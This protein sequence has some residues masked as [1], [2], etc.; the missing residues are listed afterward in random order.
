LSRTAKKYQT[1]NTYNTAP[2]GARTLKLQRDVPLAPCQD[3]AGAAPAADRL[4]LVQSELRA[5]TGLALAHRKSSSFDAV[6]TMIE[7][8]YEFVALLRAHQ[9][10]QKRGTLVAFRHQQTRGPGGPYTTQTSNAVTT[11]TQSAPT[12]IDNWDIA[13]DDLSPVRGSSVKFDAGAYYTGKEK[14]LIDEDRKFIVIDRS[15]GWQFLK[16][17][18]PPEWVMRE[19]GTPRPEQP[20]ADECTWP[21][22]LNGEPTHP[23]KYTLFLYLIDAA[24]GETLTFSS[25]TAGGRNAVSDLTAQ[26]KNMRQMR[27]GAVPIVTLQSRQMPTKFGKKPRPHFQIKGWKVRDERPAAVSDRSDNSG[28]A[29]INVYDD[30][31]PF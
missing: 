10:A 27:P 9:S 4:G 16:K 2:G 26:I 30:E 6:K 14:T 13:A 28:I 25:S 20:F 23:W 21:A 3:R 5:I 29:E 8:L 15:E 19:P 31:L 11:A 12:A 17:D 1:V 18:C 7:P 24:T 22:D